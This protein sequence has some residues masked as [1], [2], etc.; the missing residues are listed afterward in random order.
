MLR[1]QLGPNAS[2]QE[3]FPHRVQL[4]SCPAVGAV[5]LCREFLRLIQDERSERPE[6]DVSDTVAPMPTVTVRPQ[7]G[8]SA[9][10][11]RRDVMAVSFLL[12]ASSMVILI[13]AKSMALLVV[14]ALLYSLAS[15]SI[16][17]IIAVITVDYL[18]LENLPL[19]S[20]F[21]SLACAIVAFPR[22]LLIGYYRDRRE[23]YIGLYVLL[24]AVCFAVCL[25]W[26]AECIL[27]W[28]ASKRLR[29]E[30]TPPQ[31]DTAIVGVYRPRKHS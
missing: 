30:P 21:Q 28:R 31:E 12:M 22:P 1:P 2:V 10:S 9:G 20:S 16:Q 7:F 4:P 26:T 19:A 29:E 18:G 8:D 23:S 15:G 27:Q 24:A 11:N 13:Y 5:M 25:V 3:D 6:G 17:M 14:V